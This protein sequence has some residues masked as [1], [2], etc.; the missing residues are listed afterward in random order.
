MSFSLRLAI[1][2]S[3]PFLIYLSEAGVV[4]RMN[5]E[6]ILPYNLSF[7]LLLIFLVLTLKFTR[8]K[9]GFK[10]TPM[11]FLIL[12]IVLM[13]PIL[14]EVSTKSSHMGLMAA[15]VLFFFFA[16]EVLI[17]EHRGQLNKLG[18]STI[19]ALLYLSIIGFVG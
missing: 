14:P 7:G 12:F 8:R 2:L 9:N 13:V 19:P 6:L 4:T 16:Y 3:I 17:E 10:S 5:G 15:K 11:D 1:Y 18:L